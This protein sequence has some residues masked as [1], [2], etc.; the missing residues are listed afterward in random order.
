MYVSASLQMGPVPGGSD[1]VSAWRR[2]VESGAA[3]SLGG[4]PLAGL[5]CVLYIFR[6][7]FRVELV[8]PFG[9]MGVV[10]SNATWG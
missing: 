4:L 7:V 6:F 3:I 10:Q 5:G 1:R 2:V 8:F 9:R